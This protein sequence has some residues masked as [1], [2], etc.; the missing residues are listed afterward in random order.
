MPSRMLKHNVRWHMPTL[1]NLELAERQLAALADAVAAEDY[2]QVSEKLGLLTRQIQL[3]FSQPA[4]I[5][6]DSYPRFSKL[7]NAFSQLTSDLSQQQQQIK[8]SISEVAA[9]KSANK[10]SKMYQIDK[11]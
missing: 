8:D 11:R 4:L 5:T 6:P 10:I 2:T 3:L 9:V 7:A 1:D